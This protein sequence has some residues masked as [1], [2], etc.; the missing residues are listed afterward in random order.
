MSSNTTRGVTQLESSKAIR[1]FQREWLK[2]VRERVSQGEPFAICN[3]D[4]F[5][6]VL[7]IMDIPFMIINYWN[8]LIHVK[9]LADYYS[10][11]LDK[12]GYDGCHRFAGGVASTMDNDPETAPWGGLPKPAVIIAS[13]RHAELKVLEIWAREF[14][15]P[16]YPL[17]FNFISSPDNPVPPRWWERLRDHWDE[18]IDPKE[19]DVRVEQTKALISYLEVTT[20]RKFSLAKLNKAMDLVNEQMDYW[21]MARDLI[22]ETVPCPVSLRDQLTM[23]QTEWHRGTPEGR[24]FIKS[25]YEEVKYR[26]DKGMAANPDEKLRLMWIAGTPPAWSRYV[27]DKYGAVCVCCWF[28]S[29]PIDGYAR[30]VLNNDPLRTLAGR[31]MLIFA[32]TPDWLLKDA[33]L[34]QCHGMIFD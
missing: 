4:E 23:Y 24:D 33:K 13:T 34:H 5:E 15:C 7:N 22:A 21:G 20:G 8:A 25:F 32:H 9:G 12:R 1:A 2:K 30:T 14:G 18:I 10:D 27:E 28:S 31:H 26:V 29:I 3:G 19:L 16:V 17:E 6:E 11:L